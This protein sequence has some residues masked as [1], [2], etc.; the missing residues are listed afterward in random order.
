MRHERRSCARLCHLA[1]GE[2]EQIQFLLALPESPIMLLVAGRRTQCLIPGDP[3]ESLARLI[4]QQTE[5]SDERSVRGWHRRLQRWKGQSA[6]AYLR[7]VVVL[8][9][10]N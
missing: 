5:H 10:I 6:D 1:G 3:L 4:A 8:D 7:F 9:G 2:L